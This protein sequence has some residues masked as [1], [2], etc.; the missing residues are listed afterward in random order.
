MLIWIF[1]NYML[2]LLFHLFV[3]FFL[4][5]NR[6]RTLKLFLW[7]QTHGPCKLSC[8]SSKACRPSRLKLLDSCPGIQKQ[9][10]YSYF[11]RRL[12]ISKQNMCS[13][14]NDVL[15]N[16]VS[17]LLCSLIPGGLPGAVPPAVNVTSTESAPPPTSG[18]GSTP[19]AGTNSSQQQL[20]QQML[21]MFAGGSASVQYIFSYILFSTGWWLLYSV[22][23]LFWLMVTE[24]PPFKVFLCLFLFSFA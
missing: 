5:F 2:L 24:M 20:M 10:E 3:C 17:F 14:R 9:R 11:C 12:I 23:Y 1:V 6:C 15:L 16:S 19:A 7:W 8:R 18:Q 21:Q 4:F 22:I 13:R